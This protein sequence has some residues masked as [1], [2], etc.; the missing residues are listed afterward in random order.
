MPA[1]IPESRV[2]ELW[3]GTLKDRTDLQTVTQEPV[4]II[5]PGR[6]NDG[7]GA[8]LRDAVIATRCGLQQGDIEIH[9][10][11]SDWWAH[12]HHRDR[13]YNPV[14][15]HVVYH[16][17]AGKETVLQNGLEIPTLALDEYAEAQAERRITSAFTPIIRSSCRADTAVIIRF[18]DEAGEARFNAKAV[19]FHNEITLSEP[20]QALYRGIMTALGYSKNK[21]P[22]AELAR[23]VPLRELE[24]LIA[25]DE[26]DE[27]CRLKLQSRLLG[28]AGL[29]PGRRVKESPPR[30]APDELEIKLE[31][32]WKENGGTPQMSVSDWQFFKVRPGNYPTRR[33]AAMSV[34]L[35][36]YRKTG[37]LD[38]LKTIIRNTV[39]GSSKALEESLLVDADEYHSQDTGA[40]LH[41]ER[42]LLGKERA[43]EIIINVLLPFF[44]AY[45]HLTARPDLAGKML[46]VFSRYRAP[47]ENSLEKHMRK[48]LGITPATV[49]AARWRQGLLHIY[50][51]W[52][53]QG[54]CDRC[55]IH[56]NAG[57]G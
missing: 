26:P 49:A 13:T 5:Y 51:T 6:L 18:L 16:H 9:V 56:D 4:S 25:G 31:Q 36:R 38:G 39:E 10:N 41:L 29:L 21:V 7:R 37:I 1:A 8:D 23:V 30:H 11:S 32:L 57:K 20:A 50:K 24:G 33:I 15:L 14:I 44:A 55:P 43:A 2:L 12:G 3:Q 27:I 40:A 42:S 45:F 53:T 34:L 17:D 28:A 35:V 52:C 47:A 48:Q 54:I 46:D 22:M 19:V